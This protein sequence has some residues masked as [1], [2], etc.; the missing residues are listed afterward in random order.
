MG[1]DSS[2]ES[3]LDN[4]EMN[5][6]GYIG[7]D[8]GEMVK[9]ATKT[10]KKQAKSLGQQSQTHQPAGSLPEDHAQAKREALGENPA[11]HGSE[12][13]HDETSLDNQADGWVLGK[14]TRL[15]R[16]IGY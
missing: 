11:Y 3:T 13:S 2:L 5:L 12:V 6:G 14:V 7:T 8:L 4:F 10:T 9:P 16:E 15:V 1:K